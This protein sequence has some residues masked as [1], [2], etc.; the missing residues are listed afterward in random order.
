M[1]TP[2]TRRTFLGSSAAAVIV[3]GMKAQGTV[4]GANNRV[5]VCTVGINGRGGSH[6]KAFTSMKGDSEVAGLCDVDATVLARGGKQVADAQDSKP[7]ALFRD[8][9]EA[10]AAKDIDV[11]T[12]A[13]PNHW[14][15]LAA[16]LAMQ[17]GKDVYVEKPMSHN[18]FEG[19]QVVA[20]AEK[21]KKIVQHG[22]QSRSNPKLIRD[23]KLIH[24]GFIGQ[25]VESRG[26]VYKNGNRGSIGRGKPGPVPANIDWNLWQGPAQETQFFVKAGGQAK[27][28]PGMWVH[29][30]WHYNWQ[31]GNGEIGNQGVHQMDIA[32]WGHNRGM[33]V[34][35]HSA[36]GRFGMD[37]DG[38]TPNTQ[39]TT[40]SYADGTIMTF[41]VRN[42]GSF[43]EMDGGDCGNSFFGT[44]GMYVV[45]QGF[46]TYKQGKMAQREKI[47]VPGDA[48]LD[49]EGDA[50]KRF[51]NAV[52]SRKQSDAPMSV[53]DAHV[54][55][56]HCHLGNIAYRVGR[57]LEFDA[58]AE[59]FKDESVNAYLTRDYRKGFEVPR[60]ESRSST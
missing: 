44:K 20:A 42:L 57:S 43:Q 28:Q 6:L 39:A 19:R 21:Y 31:Y 24:S 7:P 8:L 37:D 17:G 33:P 18:V 11:I 25:I 49:D 41:E 1:N 48:P 32:C 55:C 13:T 12:V 29:Y 56:A 15:T 3:A 26:Y 34:R 22:T 2:L 58:K 14:H 5:R 52:R 54:S 35:V 23:M 40:F 30:D 59:R 51:L 50:F 36:G 45:G 16:I 38:Q 10:C 27:N 47:P 46:F 53:L 9:R 4:I 60:L